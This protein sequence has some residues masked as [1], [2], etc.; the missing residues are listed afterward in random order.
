MMVM[1]KLSVNSLFVY[2]VTGFIRYE[3]F[4]LFRLIFQ[5]EIVK[6]CLTM[7]EF[8]QNV[9]I[10]KTVFRAMMLKTLILTPL[11]ASQAVTVLMTSKKI[12]WTK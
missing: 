9:F 5:L 11:T 6:F 12:K 4:F 2:N 10:I 7:K 3:N 8:L 1:I